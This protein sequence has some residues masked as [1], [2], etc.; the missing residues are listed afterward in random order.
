MINSC[1]MRSRLVVGISRNYGIESAR[2]L[3]DVLPAQILLDNEN[4]K[5]LCSTR[6]YGN[7]RRNCQDVAVLTRRDLLKLGIVSGAYNIEHED[8]RMMGQFEV[9]P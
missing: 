5:R 7:S 4:D 1:D 9:Q 3:R 2:C 8:M 6:V